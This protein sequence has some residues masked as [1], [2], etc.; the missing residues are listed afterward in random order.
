MT[1]LPIRCTVVERPVMR[2]HGGKF[3]LAP[4][5]ISHFPVHRT[6]VEPFGGAASVLMQKPRSY[7]EVYN[8]TW[9]VAVDVFRCMRDPALAAEIDRLRAEVERLRSEPHCPTCGGERGPT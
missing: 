6:Y 2:W 7:A 4:W 1:A 9:R 8:D 5:I 3:R